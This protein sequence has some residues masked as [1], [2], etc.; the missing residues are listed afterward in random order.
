MENTV[1]EFFL[2]KTRN[3]ETVEEKNKDNRYIA[4]WEKLDVLYSFIGIYTIG[5]YVFYPEKCKKTDYMIK[6]NDKGYFS[7]KYLSE[8]F[9]SFPALNKAIEDSGFISVY[10]SVG[11]VIPIWPG[12]NIDRGKMAY[13][14]DIPEIYFC[15]KH[16][17]WFQILCDTYP[18][19]NLQLIN[20]KDF[21]KDTKSFLDSMNEESYKK[22]LEHIV[23]VINRRTEVLQ[24]RDDK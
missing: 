5:I 2:W 16:P 23:S 22:Y 3:K 15:N 1:K 20:N 24:K 19:A 12:G 17:R 18:E 21:N 7:I 11:N 10:D 13:C 8:N 9:E 6:R 14:F 4:S